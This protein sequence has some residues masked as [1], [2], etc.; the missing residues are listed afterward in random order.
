[1]GD[2]IPLPPVKTAVKIGNFTLDVYAYRRL[3]KAECRLAV[4]MYKS[5]KRIGKLPASGSAICVTQ[6]GYDP[7]DDI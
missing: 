4:D 2:K 7:A 6:F 1:M 3:T 5:Q